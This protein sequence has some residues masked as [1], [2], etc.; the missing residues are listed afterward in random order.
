MKKV[1][2]QLF[3][4]ADSYVDKIIA[5]FEKKYG[6][7]ITRQQAVLFSL[8]TLDSFEDTTEF[9]KAT[10]YIALTN[11]PTYS[12][13]IP[14]NKLS[15]IHRFT[16]GKARSIPPNTAAFITACVAFRA[17]TLPA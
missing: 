17:S 10:K 5:W 9:Y 16:K 15:T 7:T 13:T 11:M 8:H 12:V 4:T 2:V 1:T 14:A 3:K 6:I